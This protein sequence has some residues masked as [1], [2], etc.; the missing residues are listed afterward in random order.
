M[1]TALADKPVL[2]IDAEPAAIVAWAAREFG[3]GL[4]LAC[5]FSLE[6][7]VVVDL[8]SRVGR[9]RVFALD[10]GRLPEESYR[11]AESLAA[12]YDLAIE[13]YFPAA[14]AVEGLLRA[15]GPFSFYASLADRRECCAVRKVEPLRRA[16]AGR[17]AWLTGMRREQAASR[18]GLDPVAWDADHG[19][20]KVSPLAA[21]SRAQVDAYAAEHGVPVHPLHRRGY[22]SIGCAPCTRPVAPGQDERA[23]RWWWEAPEHKECGLHVG[24]VAQASRL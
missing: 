2:A 21:W 19:L 23:G 1:A 12:R 16:L 24:P 20:V 8:W 11:A 17:R 9:P 18:A 13:W 15:K 7:A 4:V 14:A 5:S 22:P 3:D 10:T 6:D